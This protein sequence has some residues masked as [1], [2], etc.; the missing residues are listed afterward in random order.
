[1]VSN[2]S[3]EF[4]VTHADAKHKRHG[5]WQP[6]GAKYV[7]VYYLLSGLKYSNRAIIAPADGWRVQDFQNSNSGVMKIQECAMQLHT[8]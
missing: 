4:A 3:R 8:L 2:S 7:D 6:W 1:M 5:S